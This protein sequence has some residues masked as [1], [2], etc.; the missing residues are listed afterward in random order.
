MLLYMY[1]CNWTKLWLQGLAGLIHG[2]GFCL[3][4]ALSWTFWRSCGPYPPRSCPCWTKP[5][6]SNPSTPC[7][8][9]LAQW[10][11]EL[12]SWQPFRK[13]E[14]WGCSW[15]FTQWETP[16]IAKA[17]AGLLF[18]CVKHTNLQPR[19]VSTSHSWDF[20]ESKTGK[21]HNYPYK[22]HIIPYKTH[23]N[24]IISHTNPVIWGFPCFL[25][26]VNNP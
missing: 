7:L 20:Y 1:F 6:A 13:C 3:S 11:S 23:T 12:W 26:P 19:T 18:E 2:C 24:P 14:I 17:L 9:S 10:V 25:K 15:V 22:S 4:Q 21:S 16:P 5:I 8:G